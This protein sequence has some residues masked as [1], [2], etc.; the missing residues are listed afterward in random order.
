[1]SIFA[2]GDLHLAF[3][4]RIEKPM[5]IFGDKWKNHP[6]R[7]KKFWTENVK[8]NDTVIIAGDI[9]WGLR[10]QE[11]MADFEWI[12]GLPGKKIITKGNHDLWWNSINKMNSLFDDITF[13]QN[14]CYVVEDMDVGIAGTR[15]WICPGTEGF[16]AHDEKIFTRELIRLEFSLK[17]AKSSGVGDIIAALHYP[18]TND[19]HQPSQFTEMLTDYGVKT[20][21]YGHLHGKDSFKRGFQGVLDGVEYRLVSLDYLEC[22]LKILR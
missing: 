7:L 14:H 18:P 21:I 8:E 12:H 2:V 15:G 22:K 16:D 6:Q 17:E 5:D 4:S 1:M 11:A 10:L 3:D 9:S 20:C 13:L 19:K